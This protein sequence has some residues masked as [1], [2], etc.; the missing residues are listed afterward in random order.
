MK[1]N[2]LNLSRFFSTVNTNH[3]ISLNPIHF[4]GQIT[5]YRSYPATR[6][7]LPDSTIC[8]CNTEGRWHNLIKLPYTPYGKCIAV[9]INF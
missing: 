2:K 3:K 7:F 8:S 4:L 5:T 1:I 6:R 9:N